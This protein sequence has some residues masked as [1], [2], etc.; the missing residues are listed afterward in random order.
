[1]SWSRRGILAA[2]AAAPLAGCGFHPLYGG[3]T[4]GEYDPR[5]AAIKVTPIPDREGQLLELALREKLN[6]RGVTLPT[7]YTLTV[8]LA[9]VRSDLGIQRNTTSTRSEINASASYT[10]SG[11]GISVAGSSRTVSAF[12]LQNDAWAA[13]VAEKDARERAIEDLADAIYMQ[14]S[15]WSQRQTVAR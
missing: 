15:L 4:A 14:L 7:R 8:Y 12:N 2:L 5:L 1:M 6:P 11:G 9:L 3:H 10:L 13:T